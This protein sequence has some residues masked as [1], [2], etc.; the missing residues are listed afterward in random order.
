[1]MELIRQKNTVNAETYF[2]C[3]QLQVMKY[4]NASIAYSN[5]PSHAYAQEEKDP[6]ADMMK[7]YLAALPKKE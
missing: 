4:K 5:M 2:V 6:V 3:E 7:A 1:M